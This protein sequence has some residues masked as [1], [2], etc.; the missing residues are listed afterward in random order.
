MR[1]RFA[2]MAASALS[3]PAVALADCAPPPEPVHA[4]AYGS[5]YQDSNAPGTELDAEANA[6]VDEE[7]QPVDDFLR[8]LTDIANL[9]FEDGGDPVAA[10]DCV[11]SQIA[12]WARAGALQ[13]LQ[14][15]N[16]RMT[17]G[18]RIAG[19]ALIALQAAPHTTRAD[20]L[21]RI[22]S[23]LNRLMFAQMQFWETQAPD[24]AK[25]GNLRAWAALAGAASA[26]LG[27]DPV[28]RGWS[29]WSLVF[30]ACTA[31]PDGSLPQEMRRGKFALHYQL[32]A[33]APMAVAAALL[34]RQGIPVRV[35]CDGALERIVGFALDDLETGAKS[36][37]ITGEVQ[38]YFDGTARLKPFSLA[39]IEAY[40]SM[41]GVARRAELDA[42]AQNHRPLSYSKLGGDQTL[43]WSAG[44]GT[45]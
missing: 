5:R 32:H 1:R 24:G 12:A 42:L 2:L 26:A 10:A 45:E 22:G 4:L 37:A 20:D 43:I 35:A 7:L 3:V 34:E 31:N 16:A 41:D 21:V 11:V 8:D 33:I 29:A 23:W 18:S 40:L 19:F 27:D 17:I 44:P 30:V 15:E 9:V 14:T 36:Q 25:T 13:D 28:L 38:S 6:A 39:W